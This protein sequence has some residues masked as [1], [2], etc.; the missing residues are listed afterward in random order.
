MDANALTE[1]A[2]EA[3]LAALMG[4]V[5]PMPKR[6]DLMREHKEVGRMVAVKKREALQKKGAGDQAGAI[7]ALKQAK[8]L[9]A[10]LKELSAKI[11][12]AGG[13]GGNGGGGSAAGG[14]ARSCC[15]SGGVADE[16]AES[17]G[18]LVASMQ[19][20]APSKRLGD[21]G[22]SEIQ[23]DDAM[24][25]LR[26]AM[27][28]ATRTVLATDDSVS[29]EERDALDGLVQHMRD[30]SPPPPDEEDAEVDES[31][32]QLV[33]TMGAPGSE[34]HRHSAS[35]A[36]EGADDDD[37]EDM[38]QLMASMNGETIVKAP[39][40]AAPSTVA[41]IPARAPSS[42]PDEA[43]VELNVCPPLD[44]EEA[45]AKIDELKQAALA[46][47]RAGDKAK[48]ITLFRQAK[49]IE[50]KCANSAARAELAV[51]E[52]PEQKEQREKLLKATAERQVEKR[53]AKEAAEREAAEK[54][55]AEKEAR[56]AAKVAALKS[57]ALAL[58]GAGDKAGA[59]AALR[60]AKAIEGGFPVS[61]LHDD[62]RPGALEVTFLSARLADTG[63]AG[64]SMHV[65]VN[66]SAF[67]LPGAAPATLQT[68]AIRVDADSLSADGRS[69][70]IQ[71]VWPP[72][73]RTMQFEPARAR[74]FFERRRVTVD[75]MTRRAGK[76]GSGNGGSVGSVFSSLFGAAG[77]EHV[78]ADNGD[79]AWTHFAR[80][81]VRMK[82]LLDAASIEVEVRM[83]APGD[84]TSLVPV[85]YVTLQLR[86]RESFEAQ[87]ARLAAATRATKPVNGSG[88]GGGSGSSTSSTAAAKSLPP[89]DPFELANR[90]VCYNVLQYELDRIKDEP[91]V[92]P[93]GMPNVKRAALEGRLDLM[94]ME[95]EMGTLTL[96]KY[97]ETLRVAI[98]EERKRALHYKAVPGGLPRAQR[99]L[100]HMKLME[101][102]LKD[103]TEE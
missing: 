51:R 73:A 61:D 7:D 81:E 69:Q 53:T 98:A 83:A 76:S 100:K 12:A 20:A 103:A 86:M 79:G 5:E 27:S 3:E 50:A 32:A 58:K 55:A 48:A 35:C 10:Q 43:A 37:D 23:E 62:L 75:L 39:A 49:L 57:K 74:R 15:G 84:D 22:A 67:D 17:L 101:A 18:E 40:P 14:G 52:Q 38:S 29:A 90:I 93:D 68:D 2:M 56:K 46:C 45:A 54:Q 94:M 41:P 47:K 87:E 85:A 82:G 11:A 42:T 72:A 36:T 1:E 31:L 19:E 99:A 64:S 78:A 97:A 24:E 89:E 28:T 80:G 102:E 44:A 8:A 60:Q 96:E 13:T 63:G 70:S 26:L 91:E 33:A 25:T 21:D 92:M 65:A 6:D 71:W 34:R 66:F 59:I 4:E 77:R 88:G 30:A 95:K 16:E 9:E